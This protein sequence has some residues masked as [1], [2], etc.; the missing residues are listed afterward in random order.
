MHMLQK[1]LQRAAVKYVLFKEKHLFT[2]KMIGKMPV[3]PI[4]GFQIS[5]IASL[6]V[7]VYPR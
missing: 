4:F 2:S 1:I 6:C 7:S 5:E 3:G